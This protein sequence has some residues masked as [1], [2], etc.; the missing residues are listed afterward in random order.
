[1]QGRQRIGRAVAIALAL[2][3]LGA[4][5]APAH[6]QPG[7]DVVEVF[8]ATV[9]Q[10][11]Q[12]TASV[13]DATGGSWTIQ[14]FPS[15][16][17]LYPEVQV[18]IL[19]DATFS[20]QADYNRSTPIA[21]IVTWSGTSNY[22]FQ[23]G[24]DPF[25]CTAELL[26]PQ[27]AGKSFRYRD[28][29]IGDGESVRFELTT[30]N[31]FGVLGNGACNPPQA[32]ITTGWSTDVLNNTQVF[33]SI[34]R[35]ELFENTSISRP[36]SRSGANSMGPCQVQGGCSN[37]FAWTGTLRLVKVCRTYA[38]TATT[39]SNPQTT[40]TNS[41]CESEC[42]DVSCGQEDFEV[43]PLAHPAKEKKG[44]VAFL[45]S[46][47]G[48][49]PCDGKLTLTGSSKGAKGPIKL[50]SSDLAVEPSAHSTVKVKLSRKGKAALEDA[51]KLNAT[52]KSA[53]TGDVAEATDSLQVKIKG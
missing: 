28:S 23:Q 7:D 1:M 24:P 11:G 2:A 15:W 35:Q 30:L 40:V 12:Y 53:L 3:G 21:G 19:G 52:L 6:H 45:A 49:S 46:C 4:G 10:T 51:G 41:F 39:I 29:V 42:N 18:P 36:I 33:T 16:K 5:P 47:Y 25:S 38:G 20:P 14:S 17:V 8:E 50:G 43:P 26:G 27:L 9:D 37:D 31:T 48:D 22:D 13:S 32:A 44:A 34:P